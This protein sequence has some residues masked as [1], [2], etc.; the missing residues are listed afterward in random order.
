MTYIIFPLYALAAWVMI[1]LS[2]PIAPIIALVSLKHDVPRYFKWWLTHDAPLDG[3][4]N[5]QAIYGGTSRLAT[6]KR[7]TGWLWRNKAYT[8]RYAVLGR[9][10]GANVAVIGGEVDEDPN[11]YHVYFKRDENG[12]F[13]LWLGYP[14]PWFNRRYIKGRFGWK[15]NTDNASPGD[16]MM[17]V[18][19][20]SLFKSY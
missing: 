19:S 11:Q 3:D 1:L 13:E 10:I 16:R 17:F 20:V 14:W 12:T 8:F 5:W 18:C 4:D 6:F 7:R 2:Y 15:M 9:D